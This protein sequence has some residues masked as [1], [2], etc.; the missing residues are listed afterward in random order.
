MADAVLVKHRGSGVEIMVATGHHKNV[1]D[2]VGE[3]ITCTCGEPN[4]CIPHRL[5][6][7]LSQELLHRESRSLHCNAEEVGAR[8]SYP[9]RGH[10]VNVSHCCAKES[11]R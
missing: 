5:Y 8:A 3:A 11:K 7:H 10:G 6:C 2:D 1:A 4:A 9:K